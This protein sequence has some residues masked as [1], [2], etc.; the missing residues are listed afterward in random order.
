MATKRDI[1]KKIFE[2][3]R[4][5]SEALL[6]EKSREIFRKVCET[7]AYRE[8]GAVYAYMDYNREVMTGEFIRQAW[9][10]G[11]QVAV[12]KVSGRDMIFYILKSFDQL[13]EGYFGIPEPF[14]G[15]EARQERALMIVP[16]VAFDAD[17]HRIGYGQGFYDRYLEKH[18]Q[19]PTIAVAFEFQIVEQAPYEETDIRPGFLITE[20][21]IICG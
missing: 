17:R 20:E 2:L 4:E 1:R 13:K 8:A 14:C 16:G 3:R 18:R 21:R 9:A 19:H 5:A 6:K 15:E 12:P 7:S 10:D 11:K